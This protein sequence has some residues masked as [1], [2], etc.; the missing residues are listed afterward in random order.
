MGTNIWSHPVSGDESALA[1]IVDPA[2]FAVRGVTLAA[3]EARQTGEVTITSSA[4][5]LCSPG[6]PCPMYLVV[7]SLK[8]TITP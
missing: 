5:A 7:Y 2:A 1:P 6:Q 8:V 3:F 4:G